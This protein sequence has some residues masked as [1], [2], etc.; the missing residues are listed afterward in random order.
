MAD[1]LA[2]GAGAAGEDGEEEKPNPLVFKPDLYAAA[3]ANK[4]DEV[5]KFLAEKVPATYVDEKSGWT[6][7]HWA[8]KH[9]NVEMMTKLIEGGATAPYHRM[10]A[11]ETLRQLR[12]TRATEEAKKNNNAHVTM[13]V[14]KEDNAAGVEDGGDDPAAEAPTD[15]SDG[16]SVTPSAAEASGSAGA[17]A[18]AGTAGNALVEELDEEDEDMD[19][20]VSTSTCVHIIY[21]V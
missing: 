16:A 3:M 10:V 14:P 4:V 20:E 8:A 17:A 13:D 19:Y 18:K 1:E 21:V 9:G 2:L 11:R 6:A 5:A 12:E 7:L 15:A